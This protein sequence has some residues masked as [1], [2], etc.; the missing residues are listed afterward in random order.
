M[1]E[2][3]LDLSSGKDATQII[4]RTVGTGFKVTDLELQRLRERMA[5]VEQQIRVR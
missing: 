3:P 2:R 4:G 1:I 5:R